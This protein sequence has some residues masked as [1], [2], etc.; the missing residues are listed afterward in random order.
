MSEES[1]FTI[2]SVAVVRDGE[3]GLYLEW[4]L[5]GGIDAFECA[6]LTLFAAPEANDMCA[7]DGSCE[8]VSADDYDAK[9]HSAGVFFDSWKRTEEERDSAQSELSALREEL[10]GVVA[11]KVGLQEWVDNLK[12][13][14]T[15]AEQRNARHESMLRHFANCADVF[16]VGTLAM[17]YVA[18]I[19]PTE[20]GAS[21]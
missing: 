11:E 16:Q 3:D 10:A 9:C 17:E 14:L 5:E 18:A 6:G 19:K 13:D 8:L 20:S 21:E 4:T 15:A 2:E 12:H 7:E 1:K